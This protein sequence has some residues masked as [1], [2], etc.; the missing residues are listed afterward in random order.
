MV[1]F[2]VFWLIISDLPWAS[3][4]L[5]VGFSALN[6]FKLPTKNL[7]PASVEPFVPPFPFLCI[8]VEA[9]PYFTFLYYTILYYTM[10]RR[11]PHPTSQASHSFRSSRVANKSQTP[12]CRWNNLQLKVL[13]KTKIF[14]NRNEKSCNLHATPGTTQAKR[15]TFPK[16]WVKWI[17]FTQSHLPRKGYKEAEPAK[18]LTVSSPQGNR[19]IITLLLLLV[20]FKR[21]GKEEVFGSKPKSSLKV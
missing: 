4:E 16:T 19:A 12:V 3:V 6:W 21:P 17:R 14:C 13:D 7:P 5:L 15:F 20:S 2:S 9:P 18:C 1:Q 11:P 10:L 8:E